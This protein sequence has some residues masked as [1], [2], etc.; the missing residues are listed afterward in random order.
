MAYQPNEFVDPDQRGVELPAGCKDLH[1][2]LQKMAAQKLR[3][4]SI[5]PLERGS[6]KDIPIF[7]QRLYMEHYGMSL[8]VT[9][10]AAKAILLIENR[11]CGCRLSFLLRKQQPMLA[12][13][14]QELF[15]NTGI[16]EEARDGVRLVRA[17]LPP[18][19]LEGAQIVESVIRAYSA[20]DNADL[21][22]QF[23]CPGE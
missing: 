3:A 11:H 9:I 13:V 4:Q 15:G 7:L 22:F 5:F 18:L 21:L 20:A 19:W 1:E 8:F 23:V 6:L 16:E 10:R 14:V 2:F 17:P 12:P